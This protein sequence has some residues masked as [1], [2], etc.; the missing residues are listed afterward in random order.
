MSPQRYSATYW[1]GSFIPFLINIRQLVMWFELSKTQRPRNTKRTDCNAGA[2][3]FMQAACCSPLGPVENAPS[4]MAEEV[5]QTTC[6]NPATLRLKLDG[7]RKAKRT[8]PS[9]S[10]HSQPSAVGFTGT[11]I[12]EPCSLRVEGASCKYLR[13]Y[14]KPSLSTGCMKVTSILLSP[15]SHVMV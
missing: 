11:L 12:L 14:Q 3:H 13:P 15:R 10:L 4:W 8:R 1:G 7:Q 2:T 9:Q 5:S 6:W